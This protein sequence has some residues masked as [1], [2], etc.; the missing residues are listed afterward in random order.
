MGRNLYKMKNLFFFITL[1]TLFLVS[2]QKED[3]PFVNNENDKI[4]NK[5]LEEQIEY[6]KYH[7]LKIGSVI[8][9][10]YQNAE[11]RTKLRSDLL[12]KNNNTESTILIIELIS[13]ENSKKYSFISNDD[14][15]TLING[16]NAFKDIDGRDWEPEIYLPNFEDQNKTLY[17][18]K[19]VVIPFVV[20]E[21]DD[22]YEG[23]QENNQGQLERLPDEISEEMSNNHGNVIILKLSEDVENDENDE[24]IVDIQPS[25]Y[26]S[27]SVY[28][29]WIK[30][31]EHKESWVAGASEINIKAVF[32]NHYGTTL[33]DDEYL[34]TTRSSYGKTSDCRICDVT[35][36]NVKKK[37]KID[38][39]YL[40]QY[41]WYW[42]NYYGLFVTSNYPERY[43][44]T[45]YEYDG[46]PSGF[47]PAP[48]NINDCAGSL[49]RSS[50]IDYIRSE[51]DAPYITDHME[52]PASFSCNPSKF[53]ENYNPN[54][55]GI[56]LKTTA[57]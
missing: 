44:Y 23:Y 27:K 7:L 11:F 22:T 39:N 50:N 1:T 17:P 19:P 34:S 57:Q 38:T 25:G 45:I 26:Y 30:V 15:V 18:T 3:H 2:C 47:D 51:Q 32:E 14:K 12:A 48:Y 43:Y 41:Q 40:L 13:G 52:L 6:T 16:I 35:R 4:E 5:S 20:E 31:K 36:K 56:E 24:E 9:K 33:S 37:T 42:T 55:S 46:W 54:L 8:S 21:D 28:L 53:P 10:L 49:I 29:Q